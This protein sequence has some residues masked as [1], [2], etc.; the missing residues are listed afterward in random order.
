M[1]ET[2]LVYVGAAAAEIVGCFAFLGLVEA[3]QVGALGV[4]G[5]CLPDR[6]RLAAD[7]GRNGCGG[8]RLCGLWRSLHYEIHCLALDCRR[9]AP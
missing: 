7:T 9:R 1:R 3:R 4:A 6:L 2:F 8:M 5:R